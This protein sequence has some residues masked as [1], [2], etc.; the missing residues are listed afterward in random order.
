MRLLL[1]LSLFIC[2]QAYGQDASRTFIK[3]LCAQNMWGRGYVNGGDSIA[4]KFISNEYKALGLLPF[5]NSYQ[6]YFEF[7]VNTFPKEMLMIAEDDTLKPGIDYL[8][9][10][11]SAGGTY[12]Y[13]TLYFDGDELLKKEKKVLKIP[14]NTILI[15]RNYGFARDTIQAIKKYLHELAADYPIIELTKDKLTWSVSQEKME[16]PYLLV[17]QHPELAAC[18]EIKIN[19]S[20]IWE[21]RHTASNIV[22]YLPAHKK[23][24]EFLV[25][26][27]HY[28]HLGCMGNDTYFP[29]ANDNASG[30]G[31]LVAL[32]KELRTKKLKYNIVF[33]AFAGEEIGLLG[34]KYMV[35]HPLFPLEKIKFLV[36]LDIM[37][38]GEEGIT[39]VNASL[40]PKE[41]KQ[42]QKINARKELIEAIKPRGPAANSDHYF[43]TK[44]GVPSIFIYTMGPNKNYHDVAD[45]FAALSFSAYDDIK[46]LVLL[47]LFSF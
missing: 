29:G 20:Q 7:P 47:F 44:A 6:Q 11:S 24:D 40:F 46:K 30:N 28:D 10:P 25:L 12:T 16:H 21:A 45:Q 9:D 33:I 15:V 41:F 42:L 14:E 22:G 18:K 35:E 8:V 23:S 36:N 39:V 26:S 19:I 32:A 17:F 31:M 38:S 13:K 43:F 37:G 2:L 5:Q 1:A 4:G 34:S 3:A 27:A